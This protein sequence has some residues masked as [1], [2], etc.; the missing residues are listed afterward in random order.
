MEKGITL[1]IMK[2]D[3]KSHDDYTDKYKHG[4]TTCADYQ[5]NCRLEQKSN[6]LR[7]SS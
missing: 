1:G 5:S 6:Q 7:E 2:L 4:W 3:G